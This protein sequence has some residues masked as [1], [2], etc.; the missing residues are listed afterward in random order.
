MNNCSNTWGA[1]SQWCYLT[2]LSV[3]KPASTAGGAAPS[4]INRKISTVLRKS[5]VHP[6]LFRKIEIQQRMC[7]IMSERGLCPAF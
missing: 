7:Y 5:E 4:T 3:Q 2:D 6:H 1:I